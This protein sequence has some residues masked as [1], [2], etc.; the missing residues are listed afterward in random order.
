MSIPA[1][2]SHFIWAIS[3]AVPMYFVVF[4]AAERIKY[5]KKWWILTAIVM[6]TALT[7]SPTHSTYFGFF[8]MLYVLIKIILDKKLLF[9]HIL[10]GFAGIS[11]AFIFWYGPMFMLHGYIGTL[12]S[13]GVDPD[14]SLTLVTIGGTGDRLYTISDFFIAK[15]QNMINSP[16]GI[17]IVLSLLLILGLIY[18]LVK[19]RYYL[20]KNK[21]TIMISYFVFMSIFIFSL[22]SI[23]TKKILWSQTQK[24]NRPISFGEFFSDQFFLLFLLAFMIFVLIT[25]IVVKYNN[26]EFKDDYFAIVVVWLIFAFYAVNAAPFNFK[27]SPFRAWMLLAI[28]VCILA[29]EGFFLDN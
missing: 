15:S 10:A 28:P 11:L 25:L 5:D 17:G 4:Y 26:K 16:T 21:I 23:Y 18:T 12:K 8:F 14:V 27:I 9:Y 29:A 19:Y 24:L 13:I 22:F 2:L 20:K 7:S 6:V 1:F 3:L